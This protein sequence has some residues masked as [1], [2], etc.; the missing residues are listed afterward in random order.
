MERKIWQV[1]IYRY[2]LRVVEIVKGER[3][4]EEGVVGYGLEFCGFWCCIE[5]MGRERVFIR[6]LKRYGRKN[7]VKGG[8]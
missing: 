2:Q 6:R 8:F 5:K 3:V 1:L 7:R 4:W